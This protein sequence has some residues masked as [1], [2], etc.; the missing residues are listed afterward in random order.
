MGLLEETDGD[1]LIV[2]HRALNV[3]LLSHLLHRPLDSAFGIKQDYLAV[4]VIETGV[5]TDG[6]R[7]FTV[8]LDEDRPAG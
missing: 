8:R 7:W 6:G 1:I 2:G 3:V 5:A 4:S